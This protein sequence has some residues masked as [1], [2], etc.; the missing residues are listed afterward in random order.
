M[1]DP[2]L[3]MAISRALMM[4]VAAGELPDTL[5]I[6][7][8]TASVAF[9]KRD[10][11]AAG[12][13]AAAA[14]ARAEGYEPVERVA[15]GRA[16]AFHDETLHF[17]HSIQHAEPRVDVTS[18]FEQTAALAA[19]ALRGLA[20]DAHV[21]EVEGEY[22]PGEHSV[23]ARHETKLVGL[24]QRV[25]QHGAHVGGVAVVDGADR[26]RTVL[27]PVYE[28]LD[29]D[30][31]PETTGSL[32]DED[33][34]ITWERARAAIETE[35]ASAYDLEPAELDDDTLALAERLA[36]EHASSSRG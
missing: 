9:G 35:Y 13:P 19:R 18:R 31:R 6:S 24:G 28:A 27:T 25:I 16:S 22:C 33:R 11:I 14:A 1:Q 7:R 5:R 8:P 17:G 29:L 20:I 12:Y 34:T 30:W 26:I 32:A 3:D 21:G 4:R 15:G 10:V 2:L 36:P 23:N